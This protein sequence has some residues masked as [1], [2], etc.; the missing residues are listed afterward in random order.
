MD[1][2]LTPQR[3][4]NRRETLLVRKVASSANPTV[5]SSQQAKIRTSRLQKDIE[6]QLRRRNNEQNLQV[7]IRLMQADRFIGDVI[8][9]TKAHPTTPP[10]TPTL[11][12]RHN[13]AYDDV[14]VDDADSRMH[15][16]QKVSPST[17]SKPSV[18]LN[19]WMGNDAGGF[20]DSWLVMRGR[21]IRLQHQDHVKCAL[22]GT[23]DVKSAN[24]WLQNTRGR[25]GG[26]LTPRLLSRYGTPTF[27]RCYGNT[28]D[29]VRCQVNGFSQRGEDNSYH[30]NS[31]VRH[32]DV[33]SQEKT[34][35]FARQKRNE[36]RVPPTPQGFTKAR[37]TPDSTK[38]IVI[39]IPDSGPP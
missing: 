21:N 17:S 20:N 11:P 34:T 24:P 19:T 10:T 9:D 26:V 31:G 5:M 15:S 32:S 37:R 13:G 35:T 23:R 38:S 25:T 7:F 29:D 3:R 33:R 36:F 22:T 8:K 18:I 39:R 6:R 2:L 1:P 27:E 14:T 12:L 16:R 30:G 28:A 4:N